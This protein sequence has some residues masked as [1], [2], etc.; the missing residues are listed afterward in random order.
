MTRIGLAAALLALVAAA[1]ADPLP[2][3]AA[4]VADY[5]INVRLDPDTRTLFA[6]ERVV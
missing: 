5:D 1:D 3:R 2:E 4:H 6:R